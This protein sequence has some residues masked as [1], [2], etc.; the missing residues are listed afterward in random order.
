M[1]HCEHSGFYSVKNGS[2]WRTMSKW[3]HEISNLPLSGSTLACVLR[4]D[5]G[6]RAGLEDFAKRCKKDTSGIGQDGSS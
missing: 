4:L 2:H 6:E 5:C 3:R 1:S